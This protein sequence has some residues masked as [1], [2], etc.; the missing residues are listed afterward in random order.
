MRFS[1]D[2]IHSR[3]G[4]GVSV[5]FHIRYV[6]THCFTL[7]SPGPPYSDKKIAEGQAAP[8]R[9]G[10]ALGGGNW[11]W[12]PAP[13]GGMALASDHEIQVESELFNF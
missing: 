3:C 2:S 8:V 6:S 7:C 4:G 10:K 1:G 11:G 13:A 5:A 12:V 9:R